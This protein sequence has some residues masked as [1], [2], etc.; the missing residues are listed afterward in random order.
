MAKYQKHNIAKWSIT[1]LNGSG[2]SEILQLRSFIKGKNL[3][4]NEWSFQITLE[5][6]FAREI[7]N[8]QRLAVALKPSFQVDLFAERLTTMKV[9]IWSFIL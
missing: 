2:P 8:L 4:L 6:I 7:S 5:K 9:L 3:K 1:L